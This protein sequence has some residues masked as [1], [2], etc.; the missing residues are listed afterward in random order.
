MS[1]RSA[2][3]RRRGDRRR[4]E[5]PRFWRALKGERR[6]AERRRS[7]SSG[8]PEAPTRREAGIGAGAGAGA[9]TG[10]GSPPASA[11]VEASREARPPELASAPVR[12]AAGEDAE[13]TRRAMLRQL[14]Q[15]AEARQAR[16]TR[17]R[18]PVFAHGV[19][20]KAL[21]GEFAGRRGVV[22]DA[23]Y[24]HG[25]AL[26]AFAADAAPRWV[27]FSRLAIDEDGV[28]QASEPGP[29]DVP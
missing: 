17:G 5:A 25:R 19:Q 15:A 14:L 1:V 8:A 9:G 6:H 24:I 10:P 22:T 23:D 28:P 18:R 3:E 11:P 29:V 12:P 13:A 2:L 26:I 4:H 16:A 7:V 20:V 27:G 21:R